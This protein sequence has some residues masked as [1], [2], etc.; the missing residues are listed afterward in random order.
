MNIKRRFR[1][2]EMWIIPI[3]VCNIKKHVNEDDISISDH[4]TEQIN[5]K[6]KDYTVLAQTMWNILHRL[7]AFYLLY[8]M[9]VTKRDCLIYC[10]LLISGLTIKCY[11]EIPFIFFGTLSSTLA[12]KY[13]D[14]KVFIYP[15]V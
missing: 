2:P 15:N 11:P 5:F 13:L 7:S 14:K 8:Q 1:Q 4:A 12:Y 10:H 6:S 9:S 3:A